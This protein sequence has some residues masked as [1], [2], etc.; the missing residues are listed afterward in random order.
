MQQVPAA[1]AARAWNRCNVP[2][3]VQLFFRL[4]ILPNMCKFAKYVRQ[5]A[6]EGNVCSAAVPPICLFVPAVGEINV[7]GQTL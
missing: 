2:Y 7:S 3:V 5:Q 1:A 4:F 6:V